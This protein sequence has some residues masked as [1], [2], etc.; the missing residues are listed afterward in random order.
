MGGCLLECLESNLTVNE[1]YKTTDC[2]VLEDGSPEWLVKTTLEELRLK[3]F[4][5]E[6]EDGEDIIKYC[7]ELPSLSGVSIK[8]IGGEKEKVPNNKVP[9]D[10]HCLLNC[11]NGQQFFEAYRVLHCRAETGMWLWISLSWIQHFVLDRPPPL[12]M[13]ENDQFPPKW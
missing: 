1:T 5:S 8:C 12:D 3:E 7:P 10:G 4:C 9:K 2:E 11:I 6:N 13:L